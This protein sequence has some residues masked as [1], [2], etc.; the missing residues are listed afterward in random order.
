[1]NKKTERNSRIAL[2]LLFAGITFAVILLFLLMLAA[3]VAIFVKADLLSVASG[4]NINRPLLI[5]LFVFFC[6]VVGAGVSFLLSRIL[7]EPINK[8]IN[9]INQLAA[10]NYKARLETGDLLSRHPT[11]IE[12]TDSF[13]RMAEALDKTEI[14][15]SDFIN[16]FSHEFK[17]P[18]VSIAGF[19]KLLRRGNLTPQQQT[20]Y[21][22]II[23]EESLR[24]AQMATGVLDLTK[25]ENQTSLGETTVYNLS[26]Q[27]RNCV[28]LL[29]DKWV[30]KGL[31]P[32]LLFEEY[33]IWANE[34]LLRHVWINLL[35]NAI[36]FSE[37]GC[38]FRVSAAKENG[39]IN[40]SVTKTGKTIPSAALPHIFDNFYQADESH[41]T[42]GNSIGLAVAKKIVTLHGGKISAESKAG[43]T[44]FTVGLPC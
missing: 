14:L 5:F 11:I 7:T 18:I 33:E 4:I 22:E 34:E 40:V 6:L 39:T 35:D 23:E 16:N 20:E 27:L 21:L 32:E 19:A 1:M 37:P 44:V 43:K 8:M 17:T 36:K 12:I 30:K 24:L 3:F 29:E 9:T 26:E 31:E 15:R 2:T 42:E 25:I 13:N 10:G 38:A 28:L 41:S